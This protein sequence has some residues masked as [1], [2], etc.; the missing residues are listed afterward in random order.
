MSTFTH[1]EHLRAIETAAWK[2]R[3]EATYKNAR[4]AL[5]AFLATIP[6]TYG[7]L[8]LSDRYGVTSYSLK[9]ACLDGEFYHVATLRMNKVR[10][11]PNDN[12]YRVVDE[13]ES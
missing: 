7:T 4:K 1:Y 10:Y 3:D 2:R 13:A 12:T 6:T 9:I 11:Q 8:V 5:T